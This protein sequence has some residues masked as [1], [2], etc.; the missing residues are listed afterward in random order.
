MEKSAHALPSTVPASRV[1]AW[2]KALRLVRLFR[3]HLPDGPHPLREV[4]QLSGMTPSTTCR[5]LA[6]GVSEGVFYKG[7]GGTYGLIDAQTDSTSRT[8]LQPLH[9]LSADVH[10]V[11]ATLHHRTK[12][13]ALLH[14]AVLLGDE[15]LR[16]CVGIRESSS[17]TFSRMLRSDSAA[18][19]D[20]D[21]APLQA[22]APG[23]VVLAHLKEGQPLNRRMPRIRLDAP[24]L[25]PY[26]RL[27]DGLYARTRAPVS[28]WDLIS[29][30]VWR[31]QIP[32]GSVSLAIQ[33]NQPATEERD[34][35]SMLMHVASRLSTLS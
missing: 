30:V 23:Q 4:S 12:R 20:L 11:L 2:G 25:Q 27:S 17:D 34:Y 28:G 18:T 35:A 1:S 6:A 15:P 19:S 33:S 5:V 24:L 22:D 7:G 3:D 21:A 14:T 16:K 13:V 9:Q 8:Q 31:G 29:A 10:R 32:S 26:L